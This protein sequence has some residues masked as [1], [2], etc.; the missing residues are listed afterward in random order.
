MGDLDDLGR[1]HKELLRELADLK[2]PL[3]AAMKA[4]RRTGTTQND[5]RERSG[6]KT[7]QQVRVILGEAQPSERA[8][9]KQAD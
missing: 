8:D 6:Y 4:E 2:A 3:H 5:I 7:I 1:R 9:S